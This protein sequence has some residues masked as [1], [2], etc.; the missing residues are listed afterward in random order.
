MGLTYAAILLIPICAWVIYRTNFGLNLRSVG[1]NPESTDAAGINVYRLRTIALMIGSGLIAVGRCFPFNC[2]VGYFYIRNCERPR[3]G[4]HCPDYLCQLGT[5]SGFLGR[6]AIWRG[7]FFTDAPAN[8][9]SA[10]CHMNYFWHCL[11]LFTIIAV[12]VWQ[13]GMPSYPTAMLKPYKRE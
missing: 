7:F 13:E 3:L 5:H 10:I 9:R 8:H 4:L 1:M 11:I 12:K 2:T 6:A